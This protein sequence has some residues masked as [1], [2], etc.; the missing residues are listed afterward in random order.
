MD[1]LT[2][3]GI[4]TGIPI[5]KEK[6]EFIYK[7]KHKKLPIAIASGITPEN[8]PNIIKHCNI[9]IVRSSIIDTNNNI[10]MS[11]LFKLIKAIKNN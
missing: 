4:R 8:I 5:E 10:S 1:V 3:S 6:L 2:T 9:F 11:K 7:N